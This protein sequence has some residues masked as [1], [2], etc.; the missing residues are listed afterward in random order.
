MTK[1]APQHAETGSDTNHSQAIDTILNSLDALVYVSDL[2]TYDLLYLN[3]Y[4]VSVWGEAKGKKCYQVLQS[5]QHSPCQFC[6][7]PKLLDEKGNPAG[8]HVWEFQNTQNGRWYQCRD[9][10][11]HWTDGRLVRIE[12]A[13]DIT[14]RKQMEQALIEAKSTAERLADTDELTQLYNRRAFFNLG[15]Q[16][17]QQTAQPLAFIMFDIDHFK[18]INDR[19]GHAM[20]DA[21]LIHIARLTQTKLRTNDILARLG[22]EEFGLILPNTHHEQAWQVAESIRHGFDTQPLQLNGHSIHCTAS[23]GISSLVLPQINHPD[24]AQTLLETLFNN[25]DQAMMQAKRAGRNQV[26]DAV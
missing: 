20:G 26:C 13:T 17:A 11:I 25:A 9:Q 22:G 19:W 7:N 14:E 10:A 23:F 15:R 4:G 24:E 5:A 1:I 16:I 12:I 6:T 18:R 8:V 21:A 3:D 2:D